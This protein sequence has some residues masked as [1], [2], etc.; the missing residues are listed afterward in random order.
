MSLRAPGDPTQQRTRRIQVGAIVFLMLSV[1]AFEGGFVGKASAIDLPG[2]NNALKKKGTP[3][4]K[5]VPAPKQPVTNVPTG[6]RQI[7]GNSPGS[8]RAAPG[9]GLPNNRIQTGNAALPRTGNTGLQNNTALQ[10][11]LNP[12]NSRFSTVNTSGQN[13]NLL[14]N[15]VGTNTALGKGQPGNTA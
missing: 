3:A 6:A 12:P 2:L 14:N 4:P 1:A 10:K 7:L 11:G 8:P 9:T 13:P 5:A 15:R